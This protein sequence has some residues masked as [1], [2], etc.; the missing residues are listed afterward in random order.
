[1]D[2]IDLL[3]RLVISWDLQEEQ[4]VGVTTEV[5]TWLHGQ[6]ETPVSGTGSVA[7]SPL[8][9]SSINRLSFHYAKP[10]RLFAHTTNSKHK[11]MTT[12]EPYATLRERFA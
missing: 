8:R 5:E 7:Y 10:G 9:A 3:K 4:L 6:E 1:M 2:E 11:R 12:E